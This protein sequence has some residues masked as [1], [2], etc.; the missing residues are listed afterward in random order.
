MSKARVQTIKQEMAARK[1]RAPVQANPLSGG[2]GRARPQDSP[3]KRGPERPG[4]QDPA[5][6]AARLQEL[7]ALRPVLALV[8]GSGFGHAIT[9]LQTD[10]RVPYSA[11]PGF[12]PTTVACHS[13]EVLI[14][15]L[16]NTP[17]L[18]LNGRSHF[19]EGHAM[20]IVTFAVRVL[21]AYG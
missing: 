18:V 11:L 13:G 4:T 14:G 5:A 8:L 1:R 21:A 12:P 3:H 6:A 7:S 15:R 17:V 10:V 16:A 2:R 20:S 9:N 19:Y